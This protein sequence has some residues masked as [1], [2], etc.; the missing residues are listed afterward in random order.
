M[1]ERASRC[2]L[3]IHEPSL[4]LSRTGKLVSLLAAFRSPKPF[5]TQF[6]SEHVRIGP[7]PAILTL[8]G[9]SSAHGQAL[10]GNHSLFPAGR[11]F[12]WNS[13]FSWWISAY[14]KVI[15]GGH[16]ADGHSGSCVCVWESVCLSV[17][18]CVCFPP[19]F[20]NVCKAEDTEKEKIW[21]VFVPLEEYVRFLADFCT[22]SGNFLCR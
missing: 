9:R 6:S 13:R 11:R 1:R 14:V 8:N 3:N 12:C 4:R 17:C 2:V 10:G 18:M 22:S 21:G 7:C 16:Q 5:W 15:L 20:L 19:I